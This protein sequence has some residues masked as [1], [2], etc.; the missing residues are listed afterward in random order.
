MDRFETRGQAKQATAPVNHTHFFPEAGS[1]AA[2]KFEL[3]DFLSPS[4]VRVSS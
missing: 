2:S 3:K 1:V 4:L